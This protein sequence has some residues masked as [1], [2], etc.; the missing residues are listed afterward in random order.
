MRVAMMAI[1]AVFLVLRIGWRVVIVMRVAMMV[2]VM[3]VR[4]K[5]RDRDV[6]SCMPVHADRR[7]PGELERDD[8][9]DDQGDETAHGP[10]CTDSGPATKGPIV[11]VPGS[12][13]SGP[14]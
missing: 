2:M 13:A 3:A 4:V 10:D 1:V 12:G 14:A 7:G 9:H 8:E 6:L 5:P 11:P